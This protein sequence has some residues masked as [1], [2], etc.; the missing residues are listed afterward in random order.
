[1]SK[2]TSRKNLDI[3]IGGLLCPGR[4]LADLFNRHFL[5]SGMPSTQNIN[6]PSYGNFVMP[7]TKDSIVLL[8]TSQV[9][10]SSLI[11]SLDIARVSGCDD[12]KAKPIK[13]VSHLISL[14][15]SHISNS[16]LNTGVLP[17]RLKK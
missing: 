7:A 1:M 16:V 17:D 14:P 10:I 15:L 12:L 9:E 5:N 13:A 3:K 2:H 8:P 11:K 6:N 4:I